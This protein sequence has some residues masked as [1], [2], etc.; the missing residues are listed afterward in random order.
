MKDKKGSG[1]EA[2]EEELTQEE[3]DKL[4]A[5]QKYYY[6]TKRSELIEGIDTTRKYKKKEKKREGIRR[7]IGE[8]EEKE[9]ITETTKKNYRE[10]MLVIERR[11]KK[12][13]D[14]VDIMEK[15]K[16]VKEIEN[17]LKKEYPKSYKDYISAIISISKHSENFKK[18]IGE[19]N[20]ER[21]REIMKEGNEEITEK[22]MSGKSEKEVPEWGEIIKMREE[23]EEK[24]PYTQKHLIIALY[25]YIP[26]LRDDYGEVRIK[27]P[28]EEESESEKSE[29]E[30][31]EEEK[32]NE[33]DINTGELVIRE[34][35]TKKVYGEIRINIE[36]EYPELYRIIL[37]SLIK[38]PREY[39]ITT[40]ENKA[41]WEIYKKGRLS[42]RIKYILGYTINQIR[43][44]YTTYIIDNK[45][46]YTK[47]EVIKIYRIMG[48][49][50]ETAL[51]HYYNEKKEEKEEE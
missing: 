30:E 37:E 21:Y 4:S 3:W 29:D 28:E 38:N 49:S 5:Q 32:G 18:V 46:K 44:S 25:T 15:L 40:K 41:K 19:E 6:R 2:R 27:Y 24:E 8:M 20:I 7:Y 10:K 36:K 47:K 45:S 39:L 51:L 31:E 26:P 35:K 12:K 9:E 42:D 34:Y 48:H 16:K 22:K 17:M 11:I 13:Y 43:S 1:R 14:E 23:I 50:A 33:F